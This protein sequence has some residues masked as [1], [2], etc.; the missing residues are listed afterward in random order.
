MDQTE[1]T[2]RHGQI[3]GYP[4][5]PFDPRFLLSIFGVA[6]LVRHSELG[7]EVFCDFG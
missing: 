5:C 6:G 3:R 4:S 7:G 1:S 2:D